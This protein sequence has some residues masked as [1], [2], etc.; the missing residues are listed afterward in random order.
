MKMGRVVIAM[1]IVG[2]PDRELL[3]GH[4][5]VPEGSALHRARIIEAPQERRRHC[6]HQR[7]SRASEPRGPGL[8]LAELDGPWL[9]AVRF[10]R[11]GVRTLE[12]HRALTDER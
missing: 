8:V 4:S 1:V 11:H 9:E 3:L 7:L 10:A 12:R 6:R 5:E 2:R